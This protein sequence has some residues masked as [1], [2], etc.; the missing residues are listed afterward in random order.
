MTVGLGVGLGLGDG[1]VAGVEEELGAG[2]ENRLGGG[3]WGDLG[4]GVG[5][6]P[7]DGVG[8]GVSVEGSAVLLVSLAMTF[9]YQTTRLLSRDAQTTSKSP[10]PSRSAA[11]T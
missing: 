9:S 7:G 1:L 11:T 10:S 3:V 6:G 4:T 8:A 2:V 5:D